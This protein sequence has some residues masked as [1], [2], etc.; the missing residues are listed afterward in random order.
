MILAFVNVSEESIEVF[1]ADIMPNLTFLTKEKNP[2][3]LICWANISLKDQLHRDA[4]TITFSKNQKH[5][6]WV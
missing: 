6:L 5:Y 1:N 3:T 4:S 2:H